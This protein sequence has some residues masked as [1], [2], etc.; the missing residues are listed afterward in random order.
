M[1]LD[2]V[3]PSFSIYVVSPRPD[4]RGDAIEALT[5][6]GYLVSIFAGIDAAFT[7]VA[8]NPPHVIVLEPGG[9]LRVT[10]DLLD[11][12]YT[13][14]PETHVVLVA[15]V[16]DRGELAPLLDRGV[17]DIVYLPL[18]AAVELRRA[19]DRAVERDYFMYQNERLMAA[20][21]Q[22]AAP[23]APDPAAAADGFATEL[24]AQRTVD[25]CLNVFLRRAGERAV[26]FRYLANRRTL[27]ATFATGVDP[28]VT[29][30]LGLNLNDEVP[31]IQSG[32]L[33]A[34]ERIPAFRRLVE[35]V[36]KTNAFATRALESAGEVTGVLVF[37]DQAE[38]D[39]P[40]VE[41][42]VMLD[43]AVGLLE[44]QRR[45][46]VVNTRDEGTEVL[47]RAVFTEYVTNE[48][49]RAR[50][51][52]LPVAVLAMAFDQYDLIGGEI[53]PSEAQLMLKT[54]A[55]LCL[56]Y[57]RV[58]D[59][60]GRLGASEL[61]LLLPHTSRRGAL[62]K[63]ERLR[64]ALASADFSKVV[65]THARVTVSIGVSEYP[66]LVRDAEELLGSAD[67]TLF[68]I[69]KFGNRTAV[70]EPPTHFTPDFVVRD[71]A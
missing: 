2:D 3:R 31:A 50:R 43:R 62:I 26:Y 16:G 67:E 58:N 33:R 52:S 14:L 28:E 44:T 39:P 9:D 12:V 29:R 71:L 1:N 40:G 4:D 11:R 5:Q 8:I 48:V 51:L 68:H 65:R 45:L 38:L 69:R 49:S 57:S 19:V 30:D 24:F 36:F 46:H 42:L 23:P 15:P 6:A 63:A 54:V 70:A 55:K 66:T 59:V 17:Y 10:Q 60:I 41:R 25:D 18:A 47:S 61:G 56:K 27:V 13:H 7:E 20:P 32:D 64:R 53:G 22:E 34:A 37:L 35:T 21:P